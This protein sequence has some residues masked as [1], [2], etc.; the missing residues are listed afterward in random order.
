LAEK[1]YEVFLPVERYFSRRL[2]AMRERP[3]FS[4]YLFVGLGEGQEYGPIRATEGVR[5]LLTYADGSGGRKPLLIKAGV[6]DELRKAESVGMFDGTPTRLKTGDERRIE[7]LF[8]I[9]GHENVVSA[10]LGA[11]ERV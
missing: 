8:H 9:L 3:L 11:L 6:I 2:A 1:A 10:P 7:V 4:R 5:Q